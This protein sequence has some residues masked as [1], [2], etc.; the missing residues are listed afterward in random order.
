MRSARVPVASIVL[1][2]R[3]ARSDPAS[4]TTRNVTL[5]TLSDDR[6]GTVDVSEHQDTGRHDRAE[7]RTDVDVDDPRRRAEVEAS[8]RTLASVEAATVVP[9]TDRP[10]GEVHVLIRPEVDAE[11]AARDVQSILLV[12]HGISVA[13]RDVNVVRIQTALD[14]SDQRR[15]VVLE[16]VLVTHTATE[17][18]VVVS[19]RR[20]PRHLDGTA[21][22]PVSKEARLRT[23]A[24]AT[25]DAVS[26][27]LP[28]GHAVDVASVGTTTT[29][30]HSTA[31]VLLHL[32]SPSGDTIVSGSAVV[33]RDE[34]EAVAR[35]VLDGL[36]RVLGAVA[37]PVA[38]A[39]G[40]TAD[41]DV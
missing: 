24:R 34:V 37:T 9:G 12:R 7:D 21:R 18:E 29:L 33:R 5:V 10:I 32:H 3:R 2:A 16:R 1:D 38:V 39:S 19:L 40:R 8:L 17:I 13:H 4:P 27:L 23:T 31:L 28:T 36:S 41:H 14:R 26:A 20:G 15:S 11:Q 30:D 22:G 6:N 35:A 25:L